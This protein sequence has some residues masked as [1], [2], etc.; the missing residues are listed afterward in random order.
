M[1]CTEPRCGISHSRSLSS[2]AWNFINGSFLNVFLWGRKLV[3]VIWL[4]VN[5]VVS[6]FCLRNFYALMHVAKLQKV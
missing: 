5:V 2:P 6:S 3:D 4:L 1:V